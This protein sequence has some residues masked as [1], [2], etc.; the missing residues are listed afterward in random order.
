MLVCMANTLYSLGTCGILYHVTN[1]FLAL[2]DCVSRA[3]AVTQASFVV[4]HRPSIKCFFSEPV[5]QI[6]AK[7]CRK[8]AVHHISR[9]CF[10]L[11]KNFGFLD[12]NELFLI[13]YNMEPYGSAN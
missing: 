6:N 11:F 3:I 10:L 13:F 5:K 4:V 9:P 7:F 1:S 2:L 8:V 12:F